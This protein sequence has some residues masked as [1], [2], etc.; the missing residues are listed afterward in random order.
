MGLR[1][2]ERGFCRAFFYPFPFVFPPSM[3]ATNRPSSLRIILSSIIGPALIIQASVALGFLLTT[4]ASCAYFLL[5]DPRFPAEQPLV[6]LAFAACSTLMV[7]LGLRIQ[8]VLPPKTEISLRRGAWIVAW[9]WLIACA[10]G[11]AY[12]VFSG[13]PQPENVAAYGLWR[14]FVDGFFESMSG[15]TTT[16]ASIL[17]SVEAFPRSVVFFRSLTHWIGGMGIAYLAVTVVRRFRSSREAVINSEAESPDIVRFERPEDAIRSGI[18]FMKA[19]GGLSVALFVLLLLSGFLFRSIPYERWYDTLFDAVTFT[20]SV[21]GT[22]G[23]AHYDTSAGLPIEATRNYIIAGGLRNQVSEWIIAFFMLFA[24][25]N[26]S[27]WYLFLFD[28]AKRWSI[29]RNGELR[30]YLT[31]VGI[32]VAGIAVSL[33]AHSYYPTLEQTLRYAL[34]NVTSLVSTTGLG[35]WDFFAW[36]AEAV[37]LL[38]ICFLVGG[39]VGSTAG[40]L[41][42]L[43][44]TVAYRFIRQ[45]IHNLI[46]GTH[47][48]GFTIDGERYSQRQGGLIMANIALY[49]LLFL[50][51]GILLLLFSARTVLPDGTVHALDFGTALAASIANLGNIGPAIA[52]SQG[53][54]AGP[55]GNYFRFTVEGKLVLI[56]LMYIGRVGVLTFVMMLLKGR[57]E[58]RVAESIA[59]IP[60]DLARPTLHQ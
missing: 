53:F 26:F 24:G 36:P 12:F 31:Y 42:V 44:F 7:L 30:G 1:L 56:V 52:G 4:V 28:R 37:G 25:M 17:P 13:F 59:Q 3:T 34:F 19:Y 39:S 54:N 11:A 57:G 14:R 27:L 41:K 29:F 6:L 20:F 51:G 43:R 49:Y 16:G 32:A 21:M 50:I 55:A 60:F 23:F 48:D 2:A 40:G 18:D 10:T 33:W 35:N 15:F 58:E 47:D 46:Y 5:S 8:N 45:Q 9:A 38:F 22:G